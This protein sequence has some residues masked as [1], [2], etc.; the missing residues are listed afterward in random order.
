[1]KRYALADLPTIAQQ[2]ALVWHARARE[3]DTDAEACAYLLEQ[4]AAA[5][6][7][8]FTEDEAMDEAKP[9][10]ALRVAAQ[11]LL[12][13]AIAIAE[14]AR[15]SIGNTNVECLLTRCTEVQAA[16]AR[17]ERADQSNEARE[18]VEALTDALDRIRFGF[19]EDGRVWLYLDGRI[20]VED[21]MGE[22][23]QVHPT[24]DGLR[25]IKAWGA[26]RDAALTRASTLQ[27]V[28]A[29]TFAGL[30]QKWYESLP[31]GELDNYTPK[32]ASWVG[33][34]AGCLAA[35]VDALTRASTERA[36][37]IGHLHSNGDFCLDRMPQPMPR[38][39][40]IPLYTAQP[41]HP[42]STPA[43]QAQP[44]QLDE[45]SSALTDRYQGVRPSGRA[46][47]PQQSSTPAAAI[48]SCSYYCDRPGCIKAQRDELR[49]Q[50]LD[51]MR[52][53]ARDAA[54]WR[55]FCSVLDRGLTITYCGEEYRSR[56]DLN[57]AID[58]ALS[59]TKGPKT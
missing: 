36:E 46:E 42:P 26:A 4:L 49:D 45:L 14:L 47:Q 59:T 54:R 35:C 29:L 27:P 21:T 44:D 40:P 1:M 20:A 51:A 11:K 12:N 9:A 39:W 37:P 48:H 34:Q 31:P 16:L 23:M 6:V 33:F 24:P 2:F 50:A 25:T 18:P 3:G 58:T 57:A 22:A 7:S 53:E 52:E 28:E 43:E 5:L 15:P 56:S 17:A 30:A 55:D 13:E 38:E 19:Y 8:P 10:E 41:S 32:S